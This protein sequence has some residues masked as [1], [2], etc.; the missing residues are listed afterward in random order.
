M[1]KVYFLVDHFP[2]KTET[3]VVNQIVQT[4]KNGFDV[5]II[6]NDLIDFRQ[7]SQQELLEKY[8]IAGKTH[9]AFPPIANW[10]SKIFYVLR[11]AVMNPMAFFRLLPV[12]FNSAQ[13]AYT[14]RREFLKSLHF[15]KYADV[16]FWHAQFGI[17][18]IFLAKLKSRNI[19]QGN[20][21][22]SFHGYDA[23][24]TLENRDAKRLQYVQ[25]FKLADKIIANTDF[26]K[27]RLIEL[28]CPVDKIAVIP[29]GVDTAMFSYKPRSNPGFTIISVGRLIALKGHIYGIR[30]MKILRDKGIDVNY[31]IV[32]E[33]PERI[34][35][36]TE[37]KKLNL[38][39]YTRLLGLKSQHEILDLLYKSDVFLM[40]SIT[41][42][43]G[44]MEAQGLVTIEAQA[45][46]LPVVAFNT[47]GVPQTIDSFKS[48]FLTP[49]KD[50]G[51]FAS[52]VERLYNDQQ[53]RRKMGIRASQ[54]V[55][56]KFNIEN[57]AQS[58]FTIYNKT[59]GPQE[60]N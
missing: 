35:L 1:R 14:N 23:H 31:I 7:S 22:V 12:L 10:H 26:L 44:R 18:G 58:H 27:S 59:Y 55:R 43:D 11:I 51:E 38:D 37:I 25:L 49:E 17:N 28:Y 46:G 56:E 20:F 36:E 6:A 8:E 47:G 19:I 21:I 4:I 54:F 32:G 2:A 57:I 24:S 41:D 39:R 42:S 53:L 48:G 50:V 13:S 40:T 3:F 15:I 52:Y 45:S 33:G 9:S 34:A 29:V 30:M 16:P 5:K 60:S